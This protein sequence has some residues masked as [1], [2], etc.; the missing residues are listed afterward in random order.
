M[1]TK[2]KTVVITLPI[3]NGAIPAYNSSTNLFDPTSAGA[4]FTPGGDLSG[5]ATSQTVISISG[6][7]P[8]AI[9]PST[10]QW[11]TGTSTPTLKQADNTTNSATAQTLTIQAA[12]ATGTSATGGALNLTSG[13]GTT[14][15]GNVSIQSGG[16]TIA[17]VTPSKFITSKGRRHNITTITGTYAVLTTD[18]FVIVTTNSAAFTVTL[19]SSPTTGDTYEIKD[20]VGNAATNNITIDG[21]SKNIDGSS[22]YNLNVNY[23]AILVAYNGTEWSVL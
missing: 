19:P 22:T 23:G 21:N 14:T 11:T 3:S 2:L 8:I 16:T 17:Q 15:A 10:L 4:I 5:T 1:T 20:G 12:N 7:S 6:S 9:T 13:T 18:E